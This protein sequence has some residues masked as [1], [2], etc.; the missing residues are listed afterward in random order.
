MV[1]RQIRVCGRVQGVG[2]RYAL[3]REAE[4]RGVTGWVR[5]RR[6][7][8]VEAL[9]QGDAD[10]VERVVQWAR[11]G[12]AMAVVEE[13]REEAPPEALDCVYQRF[14]QRADG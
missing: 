7:G 14:E 10:A 2:F 8:S 4:R 5:N 11:R 3:C 12:P 13:L 9:L 6:D 1:T